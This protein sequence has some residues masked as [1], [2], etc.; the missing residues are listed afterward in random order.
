MQNII[1]NN[2]MNKENWNDKA[3]IKKNKSLERQ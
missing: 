1:W 2:D 3:V